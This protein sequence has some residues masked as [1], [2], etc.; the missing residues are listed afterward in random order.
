MTAGILFAV[1]VLLWIYLGPLWGTV[2]IAL[3]FLGLAIT[4]E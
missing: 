2:V 1:L 3:L 4:Q